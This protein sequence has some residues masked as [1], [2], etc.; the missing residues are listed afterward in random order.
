M[1]LGV[2]LGTSSVKAVLVD[3]AGVTR[4]EAGAPLRVWRPQP[5][6]SEQD[7]LDWVAAAEKAVGSLP[8]DLRA[9]VRALGLSGQM[10]GATLLGD[11]DAPLRP[12]IL[13]NDGRAHAECAE[14]ERAEPDLRAITGN[15]AM[16]GFTAPKL[17]WTRRH[18]PRVAG[19]GFLD[20]CFADLPDHGVEIV[21]SDTARLGVLA[22]IEIR[23]REKLEPNAAAL[24]DHPVP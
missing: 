8:L 21:Q 10:H 2:D 22:R 7:P 15:K 24:Q 12:A 1:F 19:S 20:A 17:A 18:E 13:W 3:E 23:P 9:A 14:L 5:L 6:W 11:D 16:P 4:A